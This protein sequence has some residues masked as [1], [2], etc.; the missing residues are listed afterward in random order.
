MR[1]RP[2]AEPLTGVPGAG[3]LATR[4]S[5][6]FGI[7]NTALGQRFGF[8][9][10]GRRRGPDRPAHH[11]V[12][13]GGGDP[14]PLDDTG[15]APIA[16]FATFAKNLPMARAM[17]P[18]GRY[19]LGRSFSV[20]MR[21]REIVIDRTCARCGCEHEWG[22][23]VAYFAQRARLEEAQVTSLAHGRASDPCWR[24]ERD[25]VLVA[26]VNA[27][28]DRAVVPGALWGRLRRH[29]DEA[30]LLDLT[31]LC[32]WYHAISFTAR[33]AGTP[34]EA[35]APRFSSALPKDQPGSPPVALS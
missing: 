2:V 9:N 19:E 10:R 33:S 30:Q 16:L 34:L 1:A 21:E 26:M 4:A 5:L 27:L 14:A 28:H 15:V 35:W 13:R 7:R 24:H 31:M 3:V 32:G 23:H 11:P 22:V 8:R 25:R 17:D 29:F 20:S 18:W 6:F 12:R